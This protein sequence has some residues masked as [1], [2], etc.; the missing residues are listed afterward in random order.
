MKIYKNLTWDKF[1]C[2]MRNSLPMVMS[3]CVI[4]IA[5]FNDDHQEFLGKNIKVQ[6]NKHFLYLSIL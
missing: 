2:M 4:L 3:S 1:L 6:Q 5:I